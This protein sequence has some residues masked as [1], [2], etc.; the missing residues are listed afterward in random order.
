MKCGIA[1]EELNQHKLALGTSERK[2]GSDR[3]KLQTSQSGT[4]QTARSG[5]SDRLL[6]PVTPVSATGQTASAQNRIPAREL[7]VISKLLVQIIT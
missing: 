5:R 6:R 7:E 4:G 3:E 1:I 2:Y